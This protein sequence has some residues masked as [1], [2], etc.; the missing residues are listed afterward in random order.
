MIGLRGKPGVMLLVTFLSVLVACVALYKFRDR[1]VLLSFG[2]VHNHHNFQILNP[3]RARSGVIGLPSLQRWIV[4]RERGSGWPAN[5][6][7]C[8]ADSIAW[9]NACERSLDRTPKAVICLCSVRDP[10]EAAMGAIR[11][12]TG[13]VSDGARC[14][15]LYGAVKCGLDCGLRIL[16]QHPV[17]Y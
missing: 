6:R 7:T 3:F 1:L 12:G 2:D 14:E 11:R 15:Q 10:W 4:R 13:G 17:T 16:V 9:R 5:R 8:A